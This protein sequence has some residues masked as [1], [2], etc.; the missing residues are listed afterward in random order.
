MART[1]DEKGK[2]KKWNSEENL[3]DLKS[4][5]KYE[6]RSKIQY[7]MQRYILQLCT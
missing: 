7:K 4:K 1:D 6:V 2:R 5:R 3:K